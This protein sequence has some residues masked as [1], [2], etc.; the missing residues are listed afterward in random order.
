MIS[1]IIPCYNC[2]DYII[3]CIKSL[4]SSKYVKEIICVLNGCKDNTQQRLVNFNDTAAIAFKVRIIEL[5]IGNVSNARNVGLYAANEDFVFFLDSD[6]FIDPSGFD[7]N[8]ELFIPENPDYVGFAFTTDLTKLGEKKGSHAMFNDCK[9]Y[10]DYKKDKIPSFQSRAA[11]IKKE[12]LLSNYINFPGQMI[13]GQDTYF[14]INL[15]SFCNTFYYAPYCIYYY[16]KYSDSSTEKDKH[17]VVHNKKR[18]EGYLWGVLNADRSSKV[19]FLNITLYKT[20]IESLSRNY[21]DDPNLT[22]LVKMLKVFTKPIGVSF[23][24]KTGYLVK[25]LILAL[26]R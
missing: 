6:D 14:T 8:F 22:Y 10:L 13:N 20:C 17:N 2:E 3:E 23:I 19:S 12:V 21:K 1:V 26:K 11:I 25:Y 5:P 7:K 24:K 16:R 15:F 18:I 4:Y 9:S